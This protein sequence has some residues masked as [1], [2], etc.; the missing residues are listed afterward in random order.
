VQ[1]PSKF[2]EALPAVSPM[3]MTVVVVDRRTAPAE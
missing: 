1:L 3:A 2:H